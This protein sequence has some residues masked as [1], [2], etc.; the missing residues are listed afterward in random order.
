MV[1]NLQTLH[2]KETVLEKKGKSFEK[3]LIFYQPHTCAC[4]A[5]SLSQRALAACSRKKHRALERFVNPC[6]WGVYQGLS[7]A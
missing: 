3:M 5:E 7:L 1:A 4:S 2:N 6:R